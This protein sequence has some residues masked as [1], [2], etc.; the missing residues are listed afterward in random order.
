MSTED[1]VL[2][3][4][5]PDL[6]IVKEEKWTNVQVDSQVLSSFMACPAKYNY[7]FNRHLVPI[8]GVSK[9]IEKGQLAHIGL[10]TYWKE[11]I[12][13]GDYQV[14]S[15]AGL[16]EAKK[17]SLTF[18]NLEAEDALDVFNN[19]ISFFK[20]I[21]G[22]SW[23][24]VFVE[25][26]FKKIAYESSELKLRI[27][28]TG[29]I[30]LGLRNTSMKLLPI[31][32][33]TEAERWF[34]TSMSNQFKIYC[35]ACGVN[36]FGVQRFGFQKT[37]KPEQKF[38]MELLPFDRDILEEWRTVTLPYWVQRLLVCY[39]DGYW[40]MNTTNCV[41]G[42]FKCQFSDAYNGGICSVT[43]QVREQKLERYFKIGEDW[44]PSQF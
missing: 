42:H 26:H 30:D 7:I 2:K 23:E 36:T 33:K 37:L 22:S 20:Y 12:K 17:Q 9:S 16:E 40:P 3:P 31:D 32:N 34:Y 35:I 4:T 5:E 41:H 14:A 38:K 8:S 44:D 39:E 6:Q 1:N 29:R 43:P 10:H 24:P 27:I 25:Q 21:H 18:H 13:S 19:L 28:L 15:I 11:R